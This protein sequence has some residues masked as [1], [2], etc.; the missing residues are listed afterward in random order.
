MLAGIFIG[1]MILGI[2]AV[3]LLSLWWKQNAWRRRW[4]Q[5]DSDRDR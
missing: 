5:R 1:V 2:F 3:Q 4:R